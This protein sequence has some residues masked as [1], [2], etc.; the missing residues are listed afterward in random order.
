MSLSDWLN[1]M[2]EK[3]QNQSN[4]RVTEIFEH[5]QVIYT[6][7]LKEIIRQVGLQCTERGQLLDKIWGAYMDL[8]DKA[9]NEN[10]NEKMK[11]EN[12]YLDE[13]AALHSMYQKQLE[14][15]ILNFENIKKERDE[16]ISLLTTQSEQLKYLIPCVWERLSEIDFIFHE[17]LESKFGLD[18]SWICRFLNFQNFFE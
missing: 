13:I 3:I 5:V 18:F 4:L 6:M 2:L 9:I 7:C 8:L 15:Q 16:Q 10:S 14:F 1:K 17:V 12:Y 11:I